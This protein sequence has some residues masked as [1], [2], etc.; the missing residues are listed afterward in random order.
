MSK[1]ASKTISIAKDFSRYPAGRFRLDGEWSG[2]RFREEHLVPA[3]RDFDRVTVALNGIAGVASSFLDEAFGGLV[4][5]CGMDAT[6]LKGRLTIRTGEGYEDFAA[7]AWY[8]VERAAHA[9]R[10]A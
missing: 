6:D 9:T 2:Q 5:E 1:N 7:L 3:L 8:H 4:R 10:E